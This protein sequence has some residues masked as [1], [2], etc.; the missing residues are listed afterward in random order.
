MDWTVTKTKV[1]SV[2]RLSLLATSG[3]YG[4]QKPCGL[5]AFASISSSYCVFRVFLE[6]YEKSRK[7]SKLLPSSIIKD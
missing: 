5:R 6:D 2:D 4:L 3:Y 1:L 7:K